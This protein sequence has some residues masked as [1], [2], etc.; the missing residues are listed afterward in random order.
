MLSA[1]IR[2]L[3]ISLFRV[4]S[5]QFS[6]EFSTWLRRACNRASPM[7]PCIG[8]LGRSQNCLGS[9]Y[10]S[11]LLSFQGPQT[12][13]STL[14]TTQTQQRN[15][16][17]F[18]TP[19]LFAM[20]YPRSTMWEEEVEIQE[21][22]THLFGFYSNSND[23]LPEEFLP[24][25]PG[26]DPTIQLTNNF[27]YPLSP[28]PSLDYIDASAMAGAAGQVGAITPNQPLRHG[29]EEPLGSLTYA[30]SDQD[31][32]HWQSDTSPAAAVSFY[33]WMMSQLEVQANS[34]D[35]A[36]SN[37]P[38]ST[39]S[40]L[41]GTG[42]PGLNQAP[43]SLGS[44]T[45]TSAGSPSYL[46]PARDGSQLDANMRKLGIC[47][48]CP[49]TSAEVRDFDRH[50]WAQHP[51]HAALWGVKSEKRTCPV[52]G[53]RGRRDNVTRHFESKHKQLGRLVWR[54]GVARIL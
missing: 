54:K 15:Y 38:T 8:D 45:P 44:T 21:E 34:Y 47:P 7:S 41:R 39:T 6:V 11:T 3:H 51:E 42:P 2:F 23:M 48:L 53:R 4:L 5:L 29:L 19:V 13:K 52:C 37:F 12:L 27:A 10:V 31:L 50:L 25:M 9:H 30:G 20:D 1:T 35:S 33:Y 28:F 40:I 17:A 46:L 16:P 43:S 22:T 24:S 32:R 49:K 36:N 26:T 18:G 14:N